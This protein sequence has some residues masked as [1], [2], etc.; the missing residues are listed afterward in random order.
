MPD[1][2]GV[3][4]L[5]R[6]MFRAA[7]TSRSWSVPQSRRV[8]RLMLRP[9]RPVGPRCVGSVHLGLGHCCVIAFRSEHAAQHRPAGGEHALRHAGLRHRRRRHVADGDPA[10]AVH[11]RSRDLL[12]PVK[13]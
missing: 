1:E 10:A 12:K 13:R 7:F 2:H 6:A 8:H 9:A 11:G 5:R 3:S 4:H